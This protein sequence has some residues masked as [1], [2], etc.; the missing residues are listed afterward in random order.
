MLEFHHRSQRTQ[1]TQLVH[2]TSVRTYRHQVKRR[3][4]ND[5]LAQFK[6][7]MEKSSRRAQPQ[8]RCGKEG[9]ERM[10]SEKRKEEEDKR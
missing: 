5:P 2:T 4:S 1:F 6:E 10:Q 7:R 8:N 9:E 3:R